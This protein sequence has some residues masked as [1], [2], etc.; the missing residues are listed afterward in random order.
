ML[1]TVKEHWVIIKNPETGMEEPRI[2]EFDGTPSD[3]EAQ[4]AA[5]ELGG[6]YWPRKMEKRYQRIIVGKKLIEETVNPYGEDADGDPVLNI[7]PLPHQRT[8]SSY[9]MS[10]TNYARDINREKNKRRAQFIYAASQNINSPIIEP[11]GKTNWKG[12]PGTPGSRVEVDSSA[13]F[14]PTRLTSGSI[15]IHRFV[16]LEELADRDI[17]DQ[18][19]LHDV[20]RGKIPPGQDN[21][22]GRTVLALQ[23]LG[24]MMS[25]P[26]L[27]KLESALV[28]LGKINMSLILRHWPRQMWE[29]LLEED[30]KPPAESKEAATFEED[31]EMQLAVAK[32]YLEA[33]EKIRPII[34]EAF[35]I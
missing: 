30:E 12:N 8:R 4:Q 10:P 11:A 24:G 5:E 22:A 23:D 2:M 35:K 34:L 6:K 32:K 28:R 27:R 19:D 17:D 1:K 29:R 25:K 31:P 16:Q 15:D 33:L 20:M 21:M 9:P 14:I 13:A 26:F 7:I 18:Y 3:K